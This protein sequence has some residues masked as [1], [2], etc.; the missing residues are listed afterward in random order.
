MTEAE[1]ATTRA[2]LSAVGI[3]AA[4]APP[5]LYHYTSATGLAGIVAT[6]NV[7]ATHVDHFDDRSEWRFGLDTIQSELRAKATPEN[8]SLID[9]TATA[10]SNRL[11]AELFAAC[12]C[13]DGDLLPQWRG[14]AERGAGYAIGFNSATLSQDGEV[15]LLPVA[16]GEQ[17]TRARAGA[18]IDW[19]VEQASK[20]SG[21]ASHEDLASSLTIGLLLIAVAAKAEI[22]HHE[23]EWRILFVSPFSKLDDLLFRE[24]AGMLVPYVELTIPKR[25]DG[26]LDIRGVRCGPTL[27]DEAASA[28][29]RM[30]L[31]KNNLP[32]VEVT[33]SVAPLRR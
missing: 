8:R 23:R 1:L 12:F 33:R 29:V 11:G 4:G 10:L 14:Y 6:G 28:A 19:I 22:F 32:D 13:E 17:A 25:S 27:R 16:Y 9:R 20:A 15:L 21:N 30:L 24:A 2:I 31:D 7:F 18:A 26:R 5:T 3:D